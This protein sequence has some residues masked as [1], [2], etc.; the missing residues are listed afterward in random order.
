MF[1]I[2]FRSPPKYLCLCYDYVSIS[3]CA[4]MRCLKPFKLA[5]VDFEEEWKWHW[6]YSSRV[7]I[8][9]CSL[10]HAQESKL[11]NETVT[12]H[13]H[14]RSGQ[15]MGIHSLSRKLWRKTRM[16]DSALAR[17]WYTGV[18]IAQWTL[19]SGMIFYGSYIHLI[20]STAMYLQYSRDIL[21]AMYWLV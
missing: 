17:Y 8:S 3:W 18:E 5:K 14:L 13:I 12:N 1:A 9:Y 15:G 20:Y 11:W 2:L 4:A 7:H 19:W 10:I 6:G 21:R 16:A